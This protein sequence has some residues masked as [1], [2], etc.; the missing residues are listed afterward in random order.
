LTRWLSS[1][2]DQLKSSYNFESNRVSMEVDWMLLANDYPDLAELLFYDPKLFSSLAKHH[3]CTLWKEASIP[4]DGLRFWIRPISI[5]FVSALQGQQYQT[6]TLTKLHGKVLAVESIRQGIWSRYAG[7]S[8]KPAF[9]SVCIK[10][11]SI[12]FRLVKCTSPACHQGSVPFLSLYDEDYDACRFC[13]GN[14]LVEDRTQRVQYNLRFLAVSPLAERDENG[15]CNEREQLR[16]TM[17]I[18]LKDDLAERKVKLGD[19]VVLIGV[20]V[21]NMEGN[22]PT[23]LVKIPGVGVSHQWYLNAAS[24]QAISAKEVFATYAPALPPP[25]RN[26]PESL[27]ESGSFFMH[28]AAQIESASE[29]LLPDLKYFFKL[30]IGLLVATVSGNHGAVTGGRENVHVLCKGGHAEV[31]S[32]LFRAISAAAFP[33]PTSWLSLGDSGEIIPRFAG[34]DRDHWFME[35]SQI[36]QSNGGLCFIP[37][38]YALKKQQEAAALASVMDNQTIIVGKDTSTKAIQCRTSIIARYIPDGTDVMFANQKEGSVLQSLA[39]HFDL[40]IDV[41][42]QPDKKMDRS[43]AKAMFSTFASETGSSALSQRL[44]H[45]ASLEVSISLAA[46]NLLTAFFHTSRQAMRS[47]M[48]GGQFYQLE[49]LTRVAKA[50]AK[51]RMSAVCDIPD[52]VFGIVFIE[53]T[54]AAKLLPTL[55]KFELRPNG[56]LSFGNFMLFFLCQFNQMVATLQIKKTHSYSIKIV[57]W[58]WKFCGGGFALFV[59][60]MASLRRSNSEKVLALAETEIQRPFV[61]RTCS[62]LEMTEMTL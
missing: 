29:M 20:M 14:T 15:R 32:M 60:S 5:P 3:L 18:K 19:E 27:G 45:S 26:F 40:V 48:K 61:F 38:L 2:E 52:A 31:L 37:H 12:Y 13:S 6:R 39:R 51:L 11:C 56:T 33:I 34:S 46:K 47:D 35:A 36:C 10:F 25:L 41:M 55:L 54:R 43:I 58:L 17:I 8:K 16:R 23:S 21:L 57:G 42:E 22:I 50:F 24:M 59:K 28:C 53:E 1:V 49:S 44:L 30:K 9:I 4:L 62:R 7:K